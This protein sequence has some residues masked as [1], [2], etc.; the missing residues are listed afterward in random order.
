MAVAMKLYGTRRWFFWVVTLLL[1]ALSVARAEQEKEG[2]ASKESDNKTP[3]ANLAREPIR[4]TKHPFY[5]PPTETY[6][7]GP[8]DVLAINVWREPEISR[9]VPVRPDGK[10]SLPLIG[11]LGASGL[12]PPKLEASI[13]EELKA[14]LSNPEVTVIV[15]EVNS[16]KFNI[17]GEVARPGS[18]PLVDPLTVLDAIA[19]AGGFS[20]WADLKGVYVLRRLPDGT[21][22]RVPFNYKDVVKGKKFYQNV[23]LEPGDTIVVP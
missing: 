11:E 9:I 17:V 18:Y 21:R 1:V 5:I 7:I 2:S 19:V 15:Q 4:V 16:R 6:V 13:R 8:N 3:A 10:I 14:Y 22:I 20:E 12:T 23:E